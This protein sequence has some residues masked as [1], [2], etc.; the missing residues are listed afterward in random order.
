MVGRLVRSTS[1]VFVGRAVTL[2]SK[3]LLVLL[4]TRYL[5]RPAEYGLLFLA[6]SVLGV[7]MLFANLGFAKAGARY[8]TEYRRAAPEL[9]AVVVRKTLSFNVAAIAVVCVVLVALRGLIAAAVGQPGVA[10]LLLVGVGYV[11]FKSLKWTAVTLFQGFDMM[12]WVTITNIIADVLT[13]LVVPTAL[14]LGFGLRGVITGY[15][16]SFAVAA[17]VG[18]VVIY[19]RVGAGTDVDVER[20]RAVSSRVLRYSV[21]LTL[22]RGANTI[23]SRADVI[24]LGVFRGPTSVAFYTLGKQLADFLIAPAE[25]LGFAISPAYGEEKADGDLSRA[26]D[27]YERSFVYTLALYGPAAAG[28]VVVASPAVRLIFG[29]DYVGAGPILQI[30]SVFVFV[31]V[32]DKITNDALDYLG[33]A[34]ARAVAKGSLSVANIALNLVLIPPFGAIGAT[35]AT[36]TTYSVLVGVELYVIAD[37]LPIDRSRL[38]RAGVVVGGITVGM[39]VVVYPLAESISDIPSL[40]GVVLVG[41]V[42]WFVLTVATGLLDVRRISAPFP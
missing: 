10:A 6:I 9:V 15:T 14:V 34:R 24:L 29:A 39:S 40:A 33:R 28:V 3:G 16:V 36:V 32:I 5:L 1:I 12:R 38:L 25:A 7:A 42:V 21:P 20:E 41:I 11:T 2:A 8:I 26:A 31:R 35:V 27:L 18:L 4:L 30:F 23:D 37:E 22:A 19:R 13:L 17:G